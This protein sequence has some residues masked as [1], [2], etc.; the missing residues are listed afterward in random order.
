MA[1]DDKPATDETS[2]IEDVMAKNRE[3]RFSEYEELTVTNWDGY[4]AKP[5][6]PAT[7]AAAR[8]LASGM[9]AAMLNDADIAPGGDGSIGFEWRAGWGNT[10]PTGLRVE[11]TVTGQ[12]ANIRIQIGST[13]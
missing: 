6:S 11:M 8:W 1:D 3:D 2:P 4:D 5:I 10:V 7:V 12:L 13:R 9:P